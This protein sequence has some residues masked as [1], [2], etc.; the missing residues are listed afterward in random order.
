MKQNNDELFNMNSNSPLFSSLLGISAALLCADTL[1]RGALLC[2]FA[3]VVAVCLSAF[4]ALVN[5]KLNE[6]LS[7]WSVVLF[8]AVLS[9]PLTVALG[10]ITEPEKAISFAVIGTVLGFAVAKKGR[11]D[12]LVAEIKDSLF[13]ALTFSVGVVSFAF[14]RELLANG[15]ILGAKLFDGIEF[16]GTFYGSLFTF[17]VVAVAYRTLEALLT[18]GREGE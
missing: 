3:L 1:V 15:S 7:F 11:C 12:S 13:F 8:G 2:V 16:F 14:F 17:I 4:A 9:L 5:K 6:E 10:T 18:K